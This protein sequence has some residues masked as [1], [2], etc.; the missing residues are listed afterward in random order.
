MVKYLKK[1]NWII[2]AQFG[3]DIRIFI[4]AFPRFIRFLKSYIE[5]KKHYKGKVEI[6]PC[7]H[8]FNKSAGDIKNEYFWQDLLAAQIVLQKNPKSI[9]DIGSR[10]DGFVAHIASS[11]QLTLMDVRPIKNEIK[12]VNFLQMDLMQDVKS[13]ELFEVIT[14]LHVLEHFGL[15]RYNDAINPSGYI[16]GLNNIFKLMEEGGSFILA[17]P[18]GR[19]RVEFNANMIF[20]PFDIIQIA[21]DAGLEL[22]QIFEVHS[23]CEPTK[24]N[25]NDQT[26]KSYEAADYALLLYE[27]KK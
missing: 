10:I 12:N 20:S 17:T 16:V 2:S 23:D 3:F 1:L 18:A 27:F 4:C 14:C 8:D 7:L 9:L 21:I 25:I 13:E 6:K 11:R 22:I 15:G 19:P 24:V 26:L 5:F